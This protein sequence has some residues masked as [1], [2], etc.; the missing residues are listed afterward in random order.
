M[1]NKLI[2]GRSLL[3]LEDKGHTSYT[4]NI[5]HSF[6]VNNKLFNIIKKVNVEKYRGE[7]KFK[8]RDNWDNGF[9]K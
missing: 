6:I 1:P 7:N 4:E 5:D 8:Y 2:E 3:N 9:D